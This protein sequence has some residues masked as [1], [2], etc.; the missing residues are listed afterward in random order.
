MEAIDNN[1]DLETIPLTDD[2]EGAAI[3]T[4]IK[5]KANTGNRKSVLYIH[6]FVDYFFHLHVAQKFN[7]NG[8]DF[9]ALD[10]RKYGRSLLQQH[11]HANYC[12]S[13]DEYNEEIS[14]A[15]KQINRVSGQK[16]ILLGHSTGGLIVSKYAND[17]EQKELVS[18]LILNSPFLD[19]NTSKIELDGLKFLNKWF[20]KYL[21]PYAIAQKHMPAAYVKSI[22]K[23]YNGE[24]DFNLNWKPLLGF[25]A[26]FI[27]LKTITANQDKLKSSSN[28]TVPILLMHASKSFIPKKNSTGVESADIILNVEHMKK[29]GPKLGSNVTLLEVKDGIHDIF[30]S[31]ETARNYAFEKLF[32]WLNKLY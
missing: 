29:I 18:G 2:Y 32:D 20:G 3:A 8:F 24:W 14:Y 15:I 7:E 5:S 10:L 11:Q 26:Y 28:I 25:P 30:L 12:K 21:P 9:Y 27:W 31:K 19:M 4:L 13:L 23:K 6:G 17:G 16:V 1:F 22:H